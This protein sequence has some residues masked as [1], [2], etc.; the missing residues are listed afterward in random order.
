MAQFAL[1]HNSALPASDVFVSQY[2]AAGAHSDD[3]VCVTMRSGSA[4]RCALMK[5]GLRPA[6]ARTAH[7]NTSA[8]TGAPARHRS[9]GDNTVLSTQPSLQH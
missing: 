9:N 4:V 1:P 7:H 2:G 5:A 6:G 3:I 8:L